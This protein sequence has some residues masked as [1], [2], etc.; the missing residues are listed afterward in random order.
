MPFAKAK[1]PDRGD[2]PL[3]AAYH[4]IL[5]PVAE[6]FDTV[7]PLQ[8]TWVALPVGSEGSVLMV[9]VNE[10]PELAQLLTL[11]TIRLPVYVPPATLEAM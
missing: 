1:E 10:L 8:K 9:M 4:R 5:L 7:A 6:R 3:A 2:P 11:V